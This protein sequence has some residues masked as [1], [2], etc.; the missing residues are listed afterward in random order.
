MILMYCTYLCVGVSMK[1][2]A[3]GELVQHEKAAPTDAAILL[4]NRQPDRKPVF[5]QRRNPA[6]L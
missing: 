4:D 2:I 6:S 3:I 1:W 5:R